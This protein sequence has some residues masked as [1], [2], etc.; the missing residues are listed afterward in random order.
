MTEHFSETPAENSDE[1]MPEQTQT[2][3]VDPSQ[4]EVSEEDPS[5]MI[6]EG[7]WRGFTKEQRAKIIENSN[8]P[9]VPDTLKRFP[10]L[11]GQDTPAELSHFTPFDK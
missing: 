3:A 11:G 6:T 7:A 10:P 2:N 1:L 5:E 8:K 9:D 4:P